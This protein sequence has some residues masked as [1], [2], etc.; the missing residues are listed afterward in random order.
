MLVAENL[1]IIIFISKKQTLGNPE[2][3]SEIAILFWFKFENFLFVKYSTKSC[4]LVE[5]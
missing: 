2:E 5:S 1:L 3:A 4:L